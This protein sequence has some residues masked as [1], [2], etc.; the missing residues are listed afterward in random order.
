MEMVRAASV[1]LLVLDVLNAVGALG[2]HMCLLERH[3]FVLGTRA[4]ANRFCDRQCPVDG[5]PGSD[6]YLDFLTW[7]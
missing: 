2:T 3:L 4:G 5:A 1:A 7:G 6:G